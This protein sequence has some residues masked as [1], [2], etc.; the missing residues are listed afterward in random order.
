VW[1]FHKYENIPMLKRSDDISLNHKIFCKA[2]KI[3]PFEEFNK[4]FT[5]V[6][7][8]LIDDPPK[9][10][11]TITDRNEI[12]YGILPQYRR[13]G[14]ARKA[15]KELLDIE[16]RKYYWALIDKNNETSML[17]VQSLGFVPRGIVYGYCNPK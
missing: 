7:I 11:V 4:R 6:G 12:G 17:F 3:I 9:G 5:G 16:P 15:A 2:I 1:N 14:I 13:K 10:L 8:Y